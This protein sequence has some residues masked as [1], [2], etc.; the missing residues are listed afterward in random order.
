M[1]RPLFA[2]SVFA[3]IATGIVSLGSLDGARGESFV[4]FQRGF[5][6]AG[7]FDVLRQLARRSV[8]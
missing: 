4:F 7:D 2:L 3:L 5:Q 1:N 8:V 6:R